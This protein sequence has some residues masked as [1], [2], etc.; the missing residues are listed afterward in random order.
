MGSNVLTVLKIDTLAL[1][2][3]VDSLTVY[4]DVSNA[5]LISAYNYEHCM[6]IIGT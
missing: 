5:I 4:S 3:L 2:V 6:L 1:N